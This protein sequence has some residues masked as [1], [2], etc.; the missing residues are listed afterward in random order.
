[1]RDK[2][3]EEE[4]ANSDEPGFE[5]LKESLHVLIEASPPYSTI[6]LA[7]AVTEVRKM[8]IPLVRTSERVV[9]A[10]SGLPSLRKLEEWWLLHFVLLLLGTRSTGFSCR[11]I[12]RPHHWR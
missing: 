5:H 10:I 12:H 3:K 8:L 9:V 4:L 6:K 1:M 2:K 7:A 11:Q